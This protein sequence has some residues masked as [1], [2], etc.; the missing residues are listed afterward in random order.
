MELFIILILYNLANLFLDLDPDPWKKSGIRQNYADSTN[1]H[2]QHWS[3]DGVVSTDFFDHFFFIWTNQAG[4][5]IN[6]LR[7]FRIF[8]QDTC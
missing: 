8:R 4:L 5:L 6:S 2:P 7:Q 3:F 1:P